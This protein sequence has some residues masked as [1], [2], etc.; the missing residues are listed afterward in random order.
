MDGAQ[1]RRRKRTRKQLVNKISVCTLEL[2]I[3]GLYS[4][5]L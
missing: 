4:V 5:E 2:N 1:G 3:R